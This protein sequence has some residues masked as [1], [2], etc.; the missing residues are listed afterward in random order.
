MSRVRPFRY[1][2]EAGVFHR[3]DKRLLPMQE[4]WVQARSAADTA[5]VL[6]RFGEHRMAGPE[7]PVVNPAFDVTPHRRLTGIV[8]ERG[9][10]YPPFNEALRGALD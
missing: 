5:D 4:V 7:V 2:R 8:T 6:R 10:L 1:D 3:L 9:V